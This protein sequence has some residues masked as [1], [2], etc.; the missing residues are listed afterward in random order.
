[1]KL[2]ININYIASLRNAMG[3]AEPDLLKSSRLCEIAGAQGIAI[4]YDG[5]DANV[6]KSD[7]MYM[8]RALKIPIM[9]MIE[10]N[11]SA[12]ELAL[13]LKPEMVFVVP[14]NMGYQD[15]R[16]GFNVEKNIDRLNEFIVPMLYNGIKAGVF[17]EPKLAQIQAAYK[18][19][20]KCV[21]L[22]ARK[23]SEAFAQN[24][25]DKSLFTELKEA[26]VFAK[27]M[28]LDV[29]ISG[30][31]N[32]KSIEL[33]KTIPTVKFVNMGHS[34]ITK[35]IFDGLTSAIKQMLEIMNNR[36]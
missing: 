2:G 21:E 22:N 31:I 34:I 27:T 3:G 4:Y 7:I 32:Y 6:T 19:G 29:T 15:S 9:L 1:M 23:F 17:I 16:G 28:N 12:R 8:K 30:G 25:N 35:A 14:E 5:K 36:D 18:A 13:E 24:P 20:A 11:E 10:M 26:A 33:V